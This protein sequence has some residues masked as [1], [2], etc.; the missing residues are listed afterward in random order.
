M[1]CIATGLNGNVPILG[2]MGD[3]R[4]LGLIGTVLILGCMVCDPKLGFIGSDPI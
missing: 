3:D 1:S 2:C 4:I